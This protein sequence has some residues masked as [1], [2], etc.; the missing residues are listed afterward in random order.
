MPL[1]SSSFPTA[2]M[3]KFLKKNKNKTANITPVKHNNCHDN[4]NNINNNLSFLKKCK[5]K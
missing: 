3:S 4:N 1:P 5:K 2:T